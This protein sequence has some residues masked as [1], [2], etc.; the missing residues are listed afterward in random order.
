MSKNLT[1]TDAINKWT[2]PLGAFSILIGGVVWLT[3][4]HSIA[5]QNQ[6]NIQEIRQDFDN[7]KT[8]IYNR[9]NNLDERLARMEGKIDMLIES[10]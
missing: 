6:K 10:K 8:K 9:L 2:A 1:I 4:L 7:T 5:T 3:S